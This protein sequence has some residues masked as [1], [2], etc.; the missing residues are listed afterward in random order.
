M[1]DTDVITD[2]MLRQLLT[3]KTR[4]LLNGKFDDFSIEVDKCVAT[5]LFDLIRFG[6]MCSQH[7][8][9]TIEVKGKKN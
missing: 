3:N 1:E 9:Y 4:D 2:Q 6:G 5:E 7:D 8:D